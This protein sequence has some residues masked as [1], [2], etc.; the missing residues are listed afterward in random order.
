ML[1]EMAVQL[2]QEKSDHKEALSDLKLQHEKEVLGVRARYEKELR[3]LHEDKNRSEEEIRQQ[4][5]EEKARSKALE[6]LQQ[7]VEELQA[8]VLS[9]EG[10]KGWF[11]RRLKEAE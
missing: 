10:T 3:G 9:M 6:G 5:R 8:Q 2:M 1:D 11:E 4:L 7:R